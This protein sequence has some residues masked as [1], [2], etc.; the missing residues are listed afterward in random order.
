M[1]LA[2]DPF[3]EVVDERRRWTPEWYSFISEL[4]ARA[5]TGLQM[6]EY[7]Y[8]TNMS[9]PPSGGQVRLNNANPGAATKMWIS[10]TTNGGIDMSNFI[11]LFREASAAGGVSRA[12]L[13]D[14]NAASTVFQYN[15]TG[16]VDKGSYSELSLQALPSIA[17]S[18]GN[19]QVCLLA[20]IG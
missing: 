18:I 11:K 2:L 4:A 10:H 16:S 19:N 13:Q 20:V 1:T 14:K 3:S 5:T 6:F 17:T 7:V 8:S 15:V 9:E 12:I